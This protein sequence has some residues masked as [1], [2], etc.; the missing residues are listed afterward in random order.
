MGGS[1]EWCDEREHDLEDLK[2][3]RTGY[4]DLGRKSDFLLKDFLRELPG[5]GQLPK[6]WHYRSHEHFQKKYGSL[7]MVVWAAATN[8]HL[9]L[10]NGYRVLRIWMDVE[11]TCWIDLTDQVAS[12]LSA[13]SWCSVEP[14][15]ASNAKKSN[16]FTQRIKVSQ[17]FQMQ[18]IAKTVKRVY[19]LDS[20]RLHLHKF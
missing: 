18:D 19:G 17:R 10:I 12:G 20:S 11:N 2:Y 9:L 7:G 8:S 4:Q 3:F 5:D 15:P 13:Y 1:M 6:H 14:I 16:P